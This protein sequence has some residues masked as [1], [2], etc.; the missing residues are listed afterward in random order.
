M[1]VSYFSYILSISPNFNLVGQI[2]ASKM[3]YRANFQQRSFLATFTMN[4]FL[5]KCS[6]G[7]THIFQIT[8]SDDVIF[9]NNWWHFD[10]FKEILIF[11]ELL[12]IWNRATPNFNQKT[13]LVGIIILK[14]II[15]RTGSGLKLLFLTKMAI[16]V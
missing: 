3:D 2:T 6:L 5:I 13:P 8:G 15:L 11:L 14:Y 10:I 12:I 16:L 1:S 4:V 9:I 7:D